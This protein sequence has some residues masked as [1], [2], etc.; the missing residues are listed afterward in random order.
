VTEIP[1]EL[2]QDSRHTL[3]LLEQVALGDEGWSTVE[4]CLVELERALERGE[5]GE[6]DAVIGELELF[7]AH[8]VATR[9]DIGVVNPPPPDVR[10]HLNKIVHDLDSRLGRDDD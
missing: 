5:A 8:R 4:R 3:R 10:E 2:A 1:R 9:I 6:V 7:G